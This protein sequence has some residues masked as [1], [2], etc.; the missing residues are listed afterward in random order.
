MRLLEMQRVFHPRKID[1]RQLWKM[2]QNR[3]T[4]QSC[5]NQNKE[6]L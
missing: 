6:D 1:S 5:E 2:H 3:R 4:L